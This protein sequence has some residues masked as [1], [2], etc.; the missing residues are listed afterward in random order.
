MELFG[1]DR[2]PREFVIEMWLLVSGRFLRW[3]EI[4]FWAEHKFMGWAWFGVVLTGL[5]IL[6][7][8]EGNFQEKREPSRCQNF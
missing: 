4:L 1:R 3:Q 7:L 2:G 8:V 6:V 5:M